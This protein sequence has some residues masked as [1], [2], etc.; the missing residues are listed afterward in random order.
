VIEDNAIAV[1]VADDDLALNKSAQ[2]AI[3]IRQVPKDALVTEIANVRI[4]NA[5]PR[6]RLQQA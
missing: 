1:M 3:D 6:C 5:K 2:P 4:G